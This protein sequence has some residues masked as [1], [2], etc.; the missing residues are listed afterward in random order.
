MAAPAAGFKIEWQCVR[1]LKTQGC[2]ILRRPVSAEL[3]SDLP[4]DMHPVLR[5]VYASRGADA[6]A[7]DVSLSSLIPVSRLEGV[8]E[9]ADRLAS[10]RLSQERVLVVGDFDADGATASA[11]V[12][13]CLRAFGFER[14]DFLVPDREKFGYGLSV[15]LVHLA[16]EKSPGLIVTV[17]NGISSIAGVAAANEHGIDV[18]VTD[19]HLPG[20]ELPAAQVI[21]NPNAPDSAFP[22]KALA[23]VGV[24]FYVMAA[25][26]RRLAADKVISAVDARSICAACLDLVALGTVADL[27][28]LDANNRVLVAQ[29]LRRMRTGGARAGIQALFSAAGRN[30]ADATA[31]DLGFAIAPRLNAA[32]RLDDMT[33]G[34]MCL[35]EQSSHEAKRGAMQLSRLNDER[36]ELQKKMQLGAEVRLENHIA[37][38]GGTDT[39]ALCLFDAD[40]H[41]GVVGLV[42]TRIKDQLNRPVIAFAAGADDGSLKGSGRSVKG[43]HM[44]DVLAAI[45]ARKPGLI[46]R[47]GG[48]AMAAGLSL[49][50]DALREF[51]EAFTREVA[52]HVVNIDDSGRIWSD[53]TLDP[54]DFDL[55]FA[56]LLRTAGPWGQGFPEPAFDGRFRI[57]SQRLVGTG[58]LKLELQP[59]GSSRSI[60]A[61]AFNKPDLLPTEGDRDCVAVYRLD[62]NEFRRQRT[63]QLVVEHIECV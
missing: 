61:I 30:I 35:L 18:I 51:E 41:P 3:L 19:H 29:G 16:A 15:E 38:A 6:R 54:E 32:G 24:A 13:T 39:H 50:P 8:A 20:D 28:P 31:A 4:A 25:L 27:V 42:A 43:V 33:V 21:V 37:T 7:I 17:D 14:P 10:A 26:G 49:R 22:S 52:R 40:W 45:D 63:P 57:V 44:R 62:V 2:E 23:G 1:M 53:G 11:L 36:R 12:M 47:F 59:E 55:G 58:H 60:G 56:E 5:R 34:I 48:H 9:A 46:Q